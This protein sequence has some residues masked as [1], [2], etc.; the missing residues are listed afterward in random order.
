VVKNKKSRELK[1]KKINITLRN[2][3][4]MGGRAKSNLGGWY[5]FYRKIC[6]EMFIKN[7]TVTTKLSDCTHM[8][9]LWNDEMKPSIYK[10]QPT[11]Y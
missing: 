11:I 9:L 2:P 10:M 7:H 6:V 8:S 5:K 4:H 1:S 3:V